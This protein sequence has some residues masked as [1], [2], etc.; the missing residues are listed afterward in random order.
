LAIRARTAVTDVPNEVY[1]RKNTKK[2]TETTG[3]PVR[4]DFVS[5]EDIRP[6]TAVVANIGAGPDIMVGF[7]SDS[8]IYACKTHQWISIRSET[9]V[10]EWSAS[11]FGSRQR[12]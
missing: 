4:V 5:W 6:P 3:T 12:R 2:S 8:Q 1:W 11:L 9:A 10:S 7:S